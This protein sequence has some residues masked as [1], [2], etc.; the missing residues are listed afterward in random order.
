MSKKI[1]V[2]TTGGT[3][4]SILN[5]DSVSVDSSESRIAM[6]I[7]AAK[8]QLGLKVEVRSAIN[9][10]SE[11]LTP[12]DW[13]DILSSI[14]H[15]CSSGADGIVVTHGTD[16]MAYTVAAAY[17]LRH[18]WSNKVC[19]TGA[20]YS[21]EL[22]S[23]DTSLS[24]LSAL[25]FVASSQSDNGVY[26]AFRQNASNKEAIILN[27][28]NVKPM[29]FDETSFSS[30]YQDY[31]TTYSVESGLSKEFKPVS[32]GYPQ[33]NTT[34][35]PRKQE[36]MD[37]QSKVSCISLYPGIDLGVLEAVTANREVVVVQLYHSGTGPCGTDYCELIEHLKKHAESTSFLMGAF[38]SQHISTP[39]SSSKAIV[40]AGGIIYRD[41]QPHFLYVFTLLCLALGHSQ[42]DIRKQL[43]NWEL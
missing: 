33:I 6:E 13:L 14:E 35:L 4:G 40:D 34:T 3:I 27:G 11:S 28:F 25:E 41:V 24:L 5:A 36:V 22:P 19:F 20:F 37:A 42:A 9:K 10:N 30:T 8:S 2:I 38:P 7:E 12:K 17:A 43:S 23:S 26:L 29:S 18:I 32:T 31:I 39:Y 21:P 15:A 1:I 16:T